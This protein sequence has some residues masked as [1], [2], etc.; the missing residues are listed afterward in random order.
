MRVCDQLTTV[1]SQTGRKHGVKRSETCLSLVTC[2]TWPWPFPLK[3]EDGDDNLTPFTPNVWPL[4]ILMRSVW[5]KLYTRPLWTSWQSH[6]WNGLLVWLGSWAGRKPL[7]VADPLLQSRHDLWLG[8]RSEKPWGGL[9]LIADPHELVETRFFWMDRIVECG[10][11]RIAS[12]S[13]Y[14]RKKYAFNLLSIAL[15]FIHIYVRRYHC[16]HIINKHKRLRQYQS[17]LWFWYRDTSVIAR[18]KC[19]PVQ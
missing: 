15:C 6:A 19:Y 14:I 9:E 5:T 11:S 16:I 7:K 1:W 4:C 13:F 10:F 12:A 3:M 17:V 2:V 8:L 18:H